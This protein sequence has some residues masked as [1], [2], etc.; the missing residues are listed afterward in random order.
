MS[1]ESCPYKP[2][3]R[4]GE[5]VERRQKKLEF[6]I[7]HKELILAAEYEWRK[8]SRKRGFSLKLP[9]LAEMMVKMLKKEVPY[10]C[11]TVEWD[12]FMSL[13]GL[14]KDHLIN[15]KR[16]QCKPLTY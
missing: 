16:Q 14:L 2:K 13:A 5:I 8:T 6:A 11:K 3:C 7:K 12:I 1:F 10:S 9:P 15:L 4:H